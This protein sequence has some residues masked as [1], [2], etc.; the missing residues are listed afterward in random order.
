MDFRL[1]GLVG[2]IEIGRNNSAYI[3]EGLASVYKEVVSSSVLPFKY[4]VE[5][6]KDEGLIKCP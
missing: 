5:L 1:K 3:Y 4:K 2:G 6:W